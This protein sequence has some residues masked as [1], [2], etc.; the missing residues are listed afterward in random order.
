MKK[1]HFFI[2][3]AVLLSFFLHSC[4]KE[5][6]SEIN[7]ESTA[8]R[9]NPQQGMI[10]T[11]TNAPGQ[12]EILGYL[13]NSNGSLDL[14]STTAS[15]GTGSGTSLAA[16]GAI[17]FNL[18]ESFLFAVNPGSNSISSFHI[19]E[20]GTLDLLS[21]VPSGGT[22]PVS[23]AIHSDKLYVANA[24]SSTISGFKINF[25]GTLLPVAGST[26]S[27]SSP[28]AQPGQIAFKPDGTVLL[29]TE[30]AT[31]KIA[32]YVIDGQGKA[33][34]PSFYNTVGQTP[35][36]LSFVR[37]AF[38]GGVDY[39]LVAHGLSGGMGASMISTY[40][41]T[42]N[43]VLSNLFSPIP[44]NQTA[45][46]W[47]AT[48]KDGYYSYVVNTG[49][50]NISAF[51]TNG[52]GSLQMLFPSAGTTDLE[53]TDITFSANE[54]YVYNLNKGSH[55]ITAY[56]RMNNEKLSRISTISVPPNAAGIASVNKMV[57]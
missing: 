9:M 11:M 12:N 2:G 31:N 7:P 24:G 43:G 37:G 41:V 33:Q 50:N 38:T 23:L 52:G 35:T 47:V 1:V 26:Q 30:R 5:Q 49:S 48:T 6:A 15:G 53:P 18:A 56:K 54:K 39:M 51:K 4:S 10:F 27:L 40:S 55:T 13:Q 57:Y 28:G 19:R 14:L 34:P 32:V 20:N 25:D 3:T 8:A 16:Q 29:V 45:A 42:T 22:L 44:T 36:S 46:S 21:T 17:A